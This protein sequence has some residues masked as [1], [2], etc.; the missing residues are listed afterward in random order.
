[1]R[2]RERYAA[3]SIPVNSDWDPFLGPL[4]RARAEAGQWVLQWREFPG[5]AR[6]ICKPLLASSS[7]YPLWVSIKT[8]L[9]DSLLFP[10]P[11]F[12]CEEGP[13]SF[14]TF[15]KETLLSIEVMNRATRL[16]RWDAVKS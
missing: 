11:F 14:D 2:S 9:L 13:V 16:Y 3:P 1:M 8:Q 6:V 10:I 5:F 4:E 7:R 12:P 15:Q